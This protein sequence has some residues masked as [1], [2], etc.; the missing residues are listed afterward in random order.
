MTR[1]SGHMCRGLFKGGGVTEGGGGLHTLVRGTMFVR[2]GAVT[3]GPSRKCD[4][5]FFGKGRPKSARQSQKNSRRLWWSQRKKSRSVPEGGADFPADIFL[6]GNAQT[7]AGIAFRVAG[8][9]ANNFPAASKF[10]GKL[11]QQGISDSHSLLEFSDSCGKEK[12]AHLA[13]LA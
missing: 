13:N 2:N 9:S 3:P 12:W 5:T 7:L 1:K 6:A 11:F 10:A 8:K 4:I